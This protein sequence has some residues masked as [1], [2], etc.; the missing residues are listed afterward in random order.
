MDLGGFIVVTADV[1]DGAEVDHD[2]SM[3]L[4]ELI[5]IELGQ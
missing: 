1:A 3:D 4:R 5:G 2:L